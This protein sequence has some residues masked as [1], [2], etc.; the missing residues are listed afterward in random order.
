MMK[1]LSWRDLAIGLVLGAAL[2]FALGCVYAYVVWD[3]PSN[4][5]GNEKTTTTILLAPVLLV[6]LGLLWWLRKPL[7]RGLGRALG[8]GRSGLIGFL[9]G[10]V[11]LPVTEL[12]F[13][14]IE[15]SLMMAKLP[16]AQRAV[17]A[18]LADIAT[19][20]K[21]ADAVVVESPLL[22]KPDSL[23]WLVFRLA[24]LTGKPVFAVYDMNGGRPPKTLRQYRIG[25]G[26]ACPPILAQ[27]PGRRKP[28][29]SGDSCLIGTD[30]TDF[31]DWPAQG[32]LLSIDLDSRQ[33]GHTKREFGEGSIIPTLVV[34]T[35]RK[36]AALPQT[37]YAQPYDPDAEPRTFWATT[38]F[39]KTCGAFP[40]GRGVHWHVCTDLLDLIDVADGIFG[41]G[42]IQN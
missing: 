41:P 27:P 31:A 8:L 1:T 6:A 10:A 17:P 24:A 37:P 22:T 5:W 38:C 21:R 19:Q 16:F 35:L 36:P 26:P 12:G 2:S 15:W 25:S 30:I 28:P 9:I 34:A 20:L 42:P 7:R 40:F 13:V 11:V 3:P 18:Q 33:L 39:I 32:L 23:D 14:G 29:T 4:D